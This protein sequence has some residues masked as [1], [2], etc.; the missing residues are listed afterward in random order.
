[1]G[2]NE[3]TSAI[4]LAALCTLSSYFSTR[5]L[6]VLMR[7]ELIAVFVQGVVLGNNNPKIIMDNYGLIPNITS[8]G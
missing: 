7:H 2:F 6:G 8:K 4:H 5:F 3:A 1:M